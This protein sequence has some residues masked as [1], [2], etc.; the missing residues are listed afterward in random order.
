[1]Y[2]P[3]RR[4]EGLGYVL[5]GALVGA[6]GGLLL[7]S[8]AQL[9][10]GP[11][12][13]DSTVLAWW[14]VPA[15]LLPSMALVFFIKPDPKTSAATLERF[16]PGYR[17]SP[18]ADQTIALPGGAGVRGWL[19]HYPLRVGFLAMFAAHGIMT[20]MMAL[21]PLAMAHSGHALTMISM[22]VGVHVVGMYGLSLPLGRLADRVGRRSVILM[23]LGVVAL[24]AVLVPLTPDYW[25]AAGG[26]L[27]VGVGWSCVNVAVTALIADTVPVVER[28]RAIGRRRQCRRYR[29]NRVAVGRR[30]ARGGNGV[31]R[32]GRAVHSAGNRA[33]GARAPFGRNAARAVRAAISCL[34]YGPH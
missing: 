7:I 14:L 23:G 16:Y 11:L 34:S 21:T 32:P 24:G 6:L 28:G 26:L 10:A 1:M 33:G 18:A 29:I 22:A 4:A 30:P 3:E 2:L 12:H 25:V 31:R 5:T 9:G 15:V 19:A 20:M 13:L 8:A 27:L 17:A